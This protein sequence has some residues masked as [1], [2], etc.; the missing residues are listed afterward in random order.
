MKYLSSEGIATGIHYPI[1]I[2]LQEAYSFMGLNKG[3]F[4][5][6]EEAAEAIMSLPIY[7]EISEEQIKFVAE[8][9]KIFFS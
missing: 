8:K 2:H 6:A 3:S 9:I 7:P 5:Q 4:P 1:N